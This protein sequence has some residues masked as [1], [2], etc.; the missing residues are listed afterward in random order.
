MQHSVRMNTRT[1]HVIQYALLYIEN[2]LC[3][4]LG[5]EV[6]TVINRAL[7]AIF[8]QF[9]NLTVEGT[10]FKVSQYY[11]RRCLYRCFCLCVCQRQAYLSILPSLQGCVLMALY[12]C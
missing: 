2:K 1:S 8:H 4:H 9:K 6:T 11:Q 3:K 12:T 5:A 10:P 7:A